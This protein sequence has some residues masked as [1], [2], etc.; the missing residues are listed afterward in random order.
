[1][2][3]PPIP[4]NGNS[5][6]VGVGPGVEQCLDGGRMTSKCGF[7]QWGESP[8]VRRVGVGA[9]VEQVSTRGSGGE[10]RAWPRVVRSGYSSG[11]QVGG[12]FILLGSP[13]RARSAE[14]ASG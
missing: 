14:L 10:R 4:I 5:V 1:M 7:V 12:L 9:G 8:V 13:P 3:C 6:N 11:R 2:R